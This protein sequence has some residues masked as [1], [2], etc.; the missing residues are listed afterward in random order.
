MR[1]IVFLAL[2]LAGFGANAADW[3]LDSTRNGIVSYT[4]SVPGQQTLDFRAVVRIK[5]DMLTTVSALV[6]VERMPDWFYHMKETKVLSATDLNNL[7]VYMVVEGLGPVIDRDVVVKAEVWQDPISMELS[8]E[9]NSVGYKEMPEQG[10][11]V[12]IP[13]MT[14]G[15]RIKPITSDITEVEL[16]GSADPGGAIPV[17]VANQVV[18]LLPRESLDKLRKNLGKSGYREELKKRRETD[19]RAHLFVNIKFPSAGFVSSSN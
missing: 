5:A 8:L 7:Y 17:W 11:K 6:D 9:A 3:E 14:A 13:F 16:T 12:R 1:F 19:P 2:L 4:R 15:W 18:T 10:G